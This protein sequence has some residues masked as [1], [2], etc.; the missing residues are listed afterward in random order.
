[1][2]RRKEKI[3]IQSLVGVHQ[4][5]FYIKCLNSLLDFCQDPIKLLLHSDGS[6]STKDKE[7]ILTNL[8]EENILFSNPTIFKENTMDQLKGRPNCLKIRQNSI[9]GIEF[10]DPLF[11]QTDERYSYYIDADIL[12]KKPFEGLFDKKIIEEGAVF[13][14]DSQWDAYSLRPWQFFGL[15]KKPKIVRGITTGLVCWDKSV[16]DWD[17]LEWFLGKTQYH[18]I[19]EWVLPTAQSGLAS[20][21]NAKRVTNLQILN[22]Y[23]N[24]E[25]N[26]ETFGLHLLGSY[27]KNW[28]AKIDK[29]NFSESINAETISARF[30]N[31]LIQNPV[32]YSLNQAKRWVNTRLDRW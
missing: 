20:L 29:Q 8:G 6:L 31:C 11:A 12:F 4:I 26:Y 17:Y 18:K 23:P 7:K 19:P 1:M 14:S 5:D 28:L 10:F 13:L 27:R 16:I 15:G 22:M 25:I 9:W 24:A 3:L 30:E 21:C 32:G 2:N